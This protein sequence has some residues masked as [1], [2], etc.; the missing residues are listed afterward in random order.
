MIQITDGFSIINPVGSDWK[1]REIWINDSGY[2]PD[3]QIELEEDCALEEGLCENEAFLNGVFC[4]LRNVG[5]T[6]SVF[7]R[8][9][10][11]M[12]SAGTVVLEPNV[13]FEDFAVSMGFVFLED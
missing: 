13:E 2:I 5:Y 9:E 4:E 11:G 10:M 8:A 3:L 6:G 1:V 12:Q 7:T